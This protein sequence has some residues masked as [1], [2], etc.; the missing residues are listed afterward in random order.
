MVHLYYI[1]CLRYT[2]LVG[3]PRNTQNPTTTVTRTVLL[4]QNKEK[5][6]KRE[7]KGE[8]EG[9]EEVKEITSRLTRLFA[10]GAE[11]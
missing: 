5:E 7:E 3:N 11:L 9:E 10:V 8:E 4:L 1:S 6:E 2:I